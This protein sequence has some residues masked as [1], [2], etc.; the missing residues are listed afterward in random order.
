MMLLWLLLCQAPTFT[1][2]YASGVRLVQ[3][4]NQRAENACVDPTLM[5]VWL[6]RSGLMISSE[7]VTSS[8]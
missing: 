4:I 6:P 7:W 3:R 5:S 8:P 2:I 1:S